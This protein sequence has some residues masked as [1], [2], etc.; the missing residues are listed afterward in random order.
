MNSYPKN[1]IN[2]CLWK[3][4]ILALAMLTRSRYCF[5]RWLLSSRSSLYRMKL[6]SMCVLSTR[7]TSIAWPSTES[8]VIQ[9]VVFRKMSNE[10]SSSMTM[11]TIEWTWSSSTRTRSFSHSLSCRRWRWR[12]S[13]TWKSQMLSNVRRNRKRRR[14]CWQNRTNPMKTSSKNKGRRTWE[15]TSGK[16]G[17]PKE[18]ATQRESESDYTSIK[19]HQ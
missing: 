15:W 11:P 10:L 6:V 12:S 1:L 2:A 19:F 9:E 17:I 16:T 8:T 13:Q 18:K 3:H 7:K 14:R 5:L 4:S